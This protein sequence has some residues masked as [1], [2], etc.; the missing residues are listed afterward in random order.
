MP[1]LDPPPGAVRRARGRRA[2]LS[3]ARIVEAARGWDLEQVTV[4]SVADRLGVDRAAVHHHVGDLDGLRELVARDAFMVRLASVSVA[5]DA[6]WRDAC[7]ALAASL[8]DAVVLAGGLG[9]YVQLTSA[10]VAV[11]EPVEQ[12]LRIMVEAGF[13]DE[14]SARSLA[15]LASLAAAI[16]REHLVAQ[17]T[18]GHPQVPELRRALEDTPAGGLQI[19]RR[20]AQADLVTFNDE[21]LNTGVDLL[22]DGMELRLAAL[23]EHDV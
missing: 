10:D 4:K 11:L 14:T 8:Y 23:L 3:R 22:L 2:G 18:T 16:G 5:A 20:L 9:V 1:E 12:T 21:Q 19:L 6:H 17:R 13:D 15:T 7:R